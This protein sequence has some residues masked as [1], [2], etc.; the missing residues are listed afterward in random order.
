MKM[1]P[2]QILTTIALGSLFVWISSR[3]MHFYAPDAKGMGIYYAF[4]LFLLFSM[5]ILDLRAPS[6]LPDP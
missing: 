2:M 5:G 1:K 4:A 3:V 6:I